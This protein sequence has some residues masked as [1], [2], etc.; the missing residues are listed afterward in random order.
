MPDLKM[1]GDI[2]MGDSNKMSFLTRAFSQ[3]RSAGKLTGEDLNQMIDQGFNPLKII[4]EK[5]GLGMSD[6][7]KQME[8]GAISFDMV[9]S[10]FVSATSKGGTFY[11][12]TNK[13]AKTDFGKWNAFKGS[14]EAFA[15]KI[16]GMLAPALG[17]LIT[18][19]LNPMLDTFS[20]MATWIQ[21]NADWLG[22]LVTVVGS[23][24]LVYQGVILAT[25]AWAA[26]Q[27]LLNVAMAM[28]P[29]GLVIA[30]IAALVI[31]IVYAWNK[32]EGFR[33]VV[34][35]LWDSFKQVFENIGNYFKMIFAPIGEALDAFEKRDFKRMGKAVGQLAYNLSP[36]G[37][38]VNTAKFAQNG[39]FTNGVVDAYKTGAAK[40]KNPL[41]K[42]VKKGAEEQ[43]T[44]SND[45][46]FDS[47]KAT[48]KKKK[49]KEAD[50]DVTG[51]TGAG[52]RTINITVQR[53]TDKV[54]IHSATL[55]EGVSDIEKSF[56]EMFL[57]V[58]N[59]G[60]SI[61]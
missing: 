5:T 7:K 2:S 30:G 43:A 38:V 14:L 51:V 36:V 32:F 15:T 54:E 40:G 45:S 42:I 46:V 29:I 47:L 44:Q 33:M 17:D 48:A 10:A 41:A 18:N 16:G 9:K 28:N 55:T 3:V 6:L 8:A 4:S 57:R 19:Y 31:G 53:F 23:A 52:P 20:Q 59:S 24:I 13:I 1:I 25:K 21:S 56:T 34:L 39:G 27:T 58:L 37:M 50:K 60:A 11:D 26:A 35:G 22:L 49:D 61:G 12:M